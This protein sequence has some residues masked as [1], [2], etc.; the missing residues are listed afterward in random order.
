MN[1]QYPIDKV[2]PHL[3]R[4]R[5]TGPKS[6]MALCPAHDDR[7]PSLSVTEADD[8]SLLIHD[9]GGCETEA[10]LRCWGM[11]FSDL[12]KP[13]EHIQRF[14]KGNHKQLRRDRLTLERSRYVANV[15][16]IISDHIAKH[17]KAIEA[18]GLDEHDATIFV[19]ACDDL[20]RWAYG[21]Y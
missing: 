12:Y 10:V 17:P 11:E 9:F 14:K 3:E 20:R 21:K 13:D 16:S 8:Y 2:L 6:W 15:A 4:K 18:L 1:T 7:S 5:Q 19:G